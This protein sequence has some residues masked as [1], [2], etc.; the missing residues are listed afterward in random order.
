M[1]VTTVIKNFCIQLAF[2]AALTGVGTVTVAAE[3]PALPSATEKLDIAKAG[4]ASLHMVNLNTCYLIQGGADAEF[5]MRAEASA[6][7]LRNLMTRLTTLGT[8]TNTAVE[9]TKKISEIWTGFSGIV[10][11]VAAADLHSIPVGQ[12]LDQQ[13]RIHSALL[14]LRDMLAEN[15]KRPMTV[16]SQREVY[17]FEEKMLVRKLLNRACLLNQNVSL[18]KN[19]MAIYELKAAFEQVLHGPLSRYLAAEEKKQVREI[20]AASSEFFA[21][22]EKMELQSEEKGAMALKVTAVG[23]QLIEQLD[24][25]ASI[26]YRN[27]F[28]MHLSQNR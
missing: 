14:E 1:S 3:T 9:K 6:V 19:R 7:E 27:G 24:Q 16:E 17:I 21:V 26:P 13:P 15:D 12:Y 2:G 11:Q 10:A 4:I 5:T 23:E 28:M 20:A 18:G 25:L 8:D 22:L